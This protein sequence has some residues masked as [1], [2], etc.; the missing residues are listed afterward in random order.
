MNHES[1]TAEDDTT[2]QLRGMLFR[3]DLLPTLQLCKATRH[4]QSHWMNDLRRG[5]A[6]DQE[7]LH[8]F[9]TA[10]LRVP[11]FHSALQI[12]VLLKH[13]DAEGPV[14]KPEHAHPVKPT[15]PTSLEHASQAGALFRRIVVEVARNGEGVLVFTISTSCNGRFE[16]P[17]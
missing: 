10:R 12:R 7:V 15:S 14:T 11:G 2:G 8:P 17:R 16:K 1:P 4:S 6:R 13:H 5:V 9:K 3:N